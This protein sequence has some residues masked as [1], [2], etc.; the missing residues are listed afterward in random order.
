LKVLFA[1][2]TERLE[3]VREDGAVIPGLYAA[4]SVGRSGLLLEGHGHRLGRAFI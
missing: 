2:V 1:K 3:V 4:G